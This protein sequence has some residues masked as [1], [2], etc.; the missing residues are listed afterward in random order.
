MERTIFLAGMDKAEFKELLK[1]ALREVLQ[2]Q[3][4]GHGSLPDIFNVKEAAEF[5]KLR[6]CTVYEKTAARLLPHFKKGNKLYFY[7]KELEEW[8]RS[9]KVTT[10]REIQ[11]DAVTFVFKGKA[12]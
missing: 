6:I 12:A 7:R 4:D 5:L 3:K 9:G 8:V 10:T 11:E 2:E 1:E